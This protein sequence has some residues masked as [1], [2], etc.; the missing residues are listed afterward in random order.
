MSAFCTLHFQPSATFNWLD[1]M[2][3]DKA[4]FDPRY[5]DLTF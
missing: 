4:Y 3:T 5:V 1:A 2:S